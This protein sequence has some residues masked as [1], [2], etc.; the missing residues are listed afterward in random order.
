MHK[1]TKEKTICVKELLH[2]KRKKFISYSAI[3]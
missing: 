2:I 3:C 1:L